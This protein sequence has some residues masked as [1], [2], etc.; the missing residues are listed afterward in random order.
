VDKLNPDD[1]RPPYKQVAD[2]L[3]REITDGTLQPGA[4]LPPHHDAVARF[5]VALGTVKRAYAQLQ[6]EGLIVSRQGQG[7]YVRPNKPPAD[8]QTNAALGSILDTLADY[9][10]RIDDLERRMGQE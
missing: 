8:A 1:A 9:G 5:G 10:R 6:S 2:A 7:S 3:R 4:K